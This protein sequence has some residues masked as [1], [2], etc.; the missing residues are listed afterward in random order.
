MVFGTDDIDVLRLLRWCR[1]ASP[2]D[3]MRV[4]GK[5]TLAN[6][7]AFKLIHTQKSGNVMN[8]TGKGNEFLDR[9]L[10]GI[11]PEV[12]KTYRE[13]D[14]QRRVRAARVALTAYRAGAAVF[15]SKIEDLR[16]SPSL[17]LPGIARGRGS[18]PWSNARIAAVA[19]LGDLLAA[20]HCVC[21]GIGKLFLT[22]ELNTFQNNTARI[23][24]VRRILIFSGESY[25]DILATLEEL[26]EDKGSK[27]VSYAD[28]YRVTGLAV[29]LLPYNDTG[30][31]QL[32]IMSQTDYR[33]RLTMA[34]LRSQYQP[35]PQE[36]PEWDAFFKGTPFVMAAD[37]DLRRIDAAIRSAQELGLIP[38][39]MAALKEQA[40]EVLNA[41]YRDTCL[42]RVF[43][44]SQEAVG[45]V[46]DPAL[47]SPPSTQF[48]T[49]E[50]GV[51]RV[52]LIQ[53][54]G[55]TGGPSSKSV[56]ELV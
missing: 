23:E 50:G 2:E 12:P 44:L 1:Y 26:P 19:R 43:M 37:M 14:I 35:P 27:L 16:R 5:T 17:Y 28:A 11:P 22:D 8:L 31:L 46:A 36:H 4:F 29:H 40:E 55:K 6:L 15:N 41:R 32:R 18:N 49:G 47:Y 53:T 34:A 39:S 56:R 24:R 13:Q 20:V 30:S 25:K 51:V 38:I 42:A 54:A 48:E 10:P 3:L 45:E 9:L 33:R 7:A 52:P 21:P